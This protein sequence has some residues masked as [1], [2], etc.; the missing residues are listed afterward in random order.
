MLAIGVS[1]PRA[2]AADII[3]N[4]ADLPSTGFVVAQLYDSANA[5]GDFRDPAKQVSVAIAPDADYRIRDVAP[6]EY[7]LLVYIDE[8]SN[9]VLDQ[10]FIGFPTEAL[11]LSNDYRPKG[12]PSYERAAFAFDGKQNLMLDVQPIRILGSGQWGVGLGVIAR[13][14]VY[15][16]GAG[17]IVQPIP[18][19]TYFGERLRWVGPNL[20]YGIWG[21]GAAR[22]A[23]AA[24]WRFGA[25]EEQDSAALAG[26]GDR[27]G[28]LLV[29]LALN[30]D[31]P[32]G[33]EL[34]VSYQHDVLDTIGGGVGR[35]Q[36]SK[37]FQIGTTRVSPTVA[38]NWLSSGVADYEF[39]VPASAVTSQRAAYA[40]GS[41]LSPEVG[42]TGLVEF[43]ERWRG[44][45]NVSYEFLPNEMTDSPLIDEDGRFG[46]L[47]AIAYVF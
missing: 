1:A 23:L 7:A 41:T 32:S 22:L 35:A 37:A 12:P 40:P 45:F 36:I 14:G 19:I 44:V 17:D 39:G 4:V 3:M 18:A 8:N 30:T 20:E 28:T 33:F 47:F 42:V 29:G 34:G 27:D 2:Q 5:F 43:S 38:L 25:Y 11:W 6:G 46:G 21:G 24:S 16:G 13:S 15:L 10:N 26:L 31:L 9:G